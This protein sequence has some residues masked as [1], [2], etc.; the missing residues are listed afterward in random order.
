MDDDLWLL[1][2]GEL[3]NHGSSIDLPAIPLGFY[4]VSTDGF[5]RAEK[6]RS[7]LAT[8]RRIRGL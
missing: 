6:F 4:P 3:A 7:C 5:K 2:V 1:E 8:R